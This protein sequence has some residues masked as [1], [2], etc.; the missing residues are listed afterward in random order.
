[1]IRRPPRST[2]FPYTT[3]FRSNLQAGEVTHLQI[4][5]VEAIGR[6]RVLGETGNGRQPD[7][8]RLGGVFRLDDEMDCWVFDLCRARVHLV[9]AHNVV[10]DELGQTD[11]CLG[12]ELS[13]FI[14]GE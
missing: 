1:M 9:V 5:S 10:W 13:L 7:I 3:L 12:I 2:L 6:E 4:L 11:G 8:H 14:D